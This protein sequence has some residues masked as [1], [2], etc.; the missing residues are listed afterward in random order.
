MRVKGFILIVCLLFSLLIGALAMAALVLSELS[1]RFNQAGLQQRQQ[2]LHHAANIAPLPPSTGTA[3]RL[4]QCPAQFQIWPADWQQC[5]LHR[6]EPSGLP[7][8][9]YGQVE[10]TWQVAPQTQGGEL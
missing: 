6:A 8:H 3:L 1:S 5:R 9:S 4:P 7:L 2:A 10:L